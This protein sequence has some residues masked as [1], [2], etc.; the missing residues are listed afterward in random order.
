MLCFLHFY[1]HVYL[2]YETGLLQGGVCDYVTSL[3]IFTNMYTQIETERLIIRPIKT[4]DKHF[5]LNLL[6]TPGWLQFIG[7]REVKDDIGAEKYIQNILENKNFFYSVFELRDTKQ[8]IG[9]ITLLYRDNQEFPDIGF[10]MLTEFE[11]KGYA[12]EATAKYLEEI[13]TQKRVAKVIAMTLP[14]NS[15]SI[16][17]IE[18]LGLQYEGNVQDKTKVLRLYSL[19]FANNE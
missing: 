17:L 3:P 6:N 9:I 16:K 14:E 10:A 15:K 7:D 1:L 12:F 5:I 4:T 13:L 11:K 8:Q 18:R 2:H 19:T